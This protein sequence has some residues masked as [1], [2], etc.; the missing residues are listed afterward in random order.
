MPKWWYPPHWHYTGVMVATCVHFLFPSF[1]FS[2]VHH[3]H[4]WQTQNPPLSTPPMATKP[5]KKNFNQKKIQPS[6]TPTKR[7]N[8]QSSIP[9]PTTQTHLY[10]NPIFKPQLQTQKTQTQKTQTH[11]HKIFR[12]VI[13]NCQP[14]PI[15]TENPNPNLGILRLKTKITK[16]RSGFLFLGIYLCVD[17][18]GECDWRK[19]KE[20]KRRKER[21]TKL[22]RRA[23]K[24][25]LLVVE[26]VWWR[27]KER[28]KKKEWRRRTK[29]KVVGGVVGMKKKERRSR[30]KAKKEASGSLWKKKERKKKWKKKVE[31]HCFL[32]VTS[33]ENGSHKFNFFYHFA[34]IT[35]NP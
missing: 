33:Q 28:K 7:K 21:K 20:R 30:G 16:M 35:H 5:K 12:S 19:K 34:T 13:Q 32:T 6:A 3:H 24:K 11:Q 1:I 14:K 29:K 8:F 4:Q 25:N 27:K 31:W 22:G 18:H 9:P 15:N 23:E 26:W 17:E 2:Q 10:H